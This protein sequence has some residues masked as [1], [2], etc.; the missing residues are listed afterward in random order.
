MHEITNYHH[1]QY[2]DYSYQLNHW[3]QTCF[4]STR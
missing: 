1:T 4:L 3:I 2:K